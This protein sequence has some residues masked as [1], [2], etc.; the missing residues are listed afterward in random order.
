MQELDERA[1]LFVT[2]T[3]ADDG[4]LALISEPQVDPLGVLSRPEDIVF[5]TSGAET[6]IVDD[7]KTS[8]EDLDLQH[9]RDREDL[10]IDVYKRQA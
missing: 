3:G 6:F 1:F 5:G 10:P 7:T 2:Q 4:R 8:F 9:N